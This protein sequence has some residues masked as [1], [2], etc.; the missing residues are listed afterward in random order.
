MWPIQLAFH[1]YLFCVG[2]SS[3]PSLKIILCHFS[4]DKSNWS[5]TFSSTTFQ[6]FPGVYD[7]LLEAS[8]FHIGLRNLFVLLCWMSKKFSSLIWKLI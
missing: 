4:H 6:N 3:A 8:T 7:L 2:C 5:S 1:L